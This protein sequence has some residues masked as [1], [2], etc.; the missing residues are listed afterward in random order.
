MTT[1]RATVH[2]ADGLELPAVMTAAELRELLGISENSL[3]E[4]LRS[5]GDLYYLTI[6][7]GGRAIRISGGRVLR[8]L[9]GRG[10]DLGAPISEDWPRAASG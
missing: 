9:D 10:E 4:R 3:Y 2:G 5:G 8:L 1:D 7:V 6:P